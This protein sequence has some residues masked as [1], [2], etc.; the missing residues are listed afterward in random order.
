MQFLLATEVVNAHLRHLSLVTQVSLVADQKE[1]SVFFGIVFNF[2]H[3]KFADVLEAERISEVKNQQ[4]TLTAPVICTGDGPEAFLP[5]SV[6]DLK[7]DILVV[8][9]DRFETEVDSNSGQVVLRELVFDE[10][11]QNS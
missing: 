4:N 6:P 1:N 3:P 5:S 7:L 8:D 11:N 10:A 9:L 2:V